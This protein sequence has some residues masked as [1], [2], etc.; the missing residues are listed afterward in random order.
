M[1]ISVSNAGLAARRLACAIAQGCL[2]SACLAASPGDALP[3][4]DAHASGFFINANGD[5]LTARHAVANCGSVYVVKDSRAVRASV[6]A[7]SQTLDL[8]VLGTSLKPY[9]SATFA[10]A[11]LTGSHSIGVFTEAYS[12]LR[13]LPDRGRLLS[14]ALTIPL[15]SSGQPAGGEAAAGGLQLLSGAQ[16]GASGSAVV[17]NSGLLLGV[18]VERVAASPGATGRMLSR[19]AVAAGAPAGATQV[20]AVSSAQVKD[21]LRASGIAFAESDAPQIGA[22]QSPA[23]RAATLAVGVICG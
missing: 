3:S 20:H 5:V 1:G 19:A 11:G 4:L 21:F 8:A 16:P 6:T 2:A 15:P 7:L 12:V 14:N 23:A 10:Q 17:G 13:R 22:T 18:V 9:L